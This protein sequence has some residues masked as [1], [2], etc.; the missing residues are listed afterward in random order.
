MELYVQISFW[1][2][3]INIIYCATLL[4]FEKYPRSQEYSQ[5]SDT[6]SLLTS[7]TLT[8]WAGSLLICN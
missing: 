6:L 3:V 7:I 8:Y 2:G 5:A 1:I 4:A